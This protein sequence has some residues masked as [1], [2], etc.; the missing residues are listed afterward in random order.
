M[1]DSSV[2][3][4]G[5]KHIFVA[6]GLAATLLVVPA[7]A[8]VPQV[9]APAPDFHASTFDDQDVSLADFKGQVLI[10]NFWAT[11]CAPCKKE[12]PLLDGYYKLASKYGFR[13]LAVTIDDNVPIRDL[14][15]LASKVSFQMARHFHGDYKTL[16]GVP[17]N[18]VIDRAG[19]VRYAKADAFELD[20]LNALIIPLL[21]EAAPDGSTPALKGQPAKAE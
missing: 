15:P 12:L 6:A 11:W 10:I 21:N 9:N 14:K 8:G 19:I 16:G 20:T 17:T 5:L 2:M 1:R 4:S 13:I 3:A 7:K 18:Y